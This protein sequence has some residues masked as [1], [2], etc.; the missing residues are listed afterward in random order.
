MRFVNRPVSPRR[1]P[2]RKSRRPSS[3][4]SP[5]KLGLECLEQRTLLTTLVAQGS[6]WSFLDN[7]TDQ[8]GLGTQNPAD[9]TWFAAPDYD[10][11]SEDE[12]QR[13]VSFGTPE[14]VDSSGETRA[15]GLFE[16]QAE[17][18][19]NSVAAVCDEQEL[20]YDKLNRRANQM[21][22]ISGS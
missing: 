1:R 18:V 3:L 15:H 8:G 5:L 20:T 17:R 14:P 2:R 13:L 22:R 21:A 16:R 11:V 4:K 19:G 9:D 10:I 12:R 7:G 6:V